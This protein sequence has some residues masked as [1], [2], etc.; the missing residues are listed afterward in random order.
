M[1]KQRHLEHD[2]RAVAGEIV[3]VRHGEKTVRIGFV[4]AVTPDGGILWIEGHGAEP[5][6]MFERTEGFHVWIEYK[7]EAGVCR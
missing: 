1:T 3:E 7:W 5:R 4:D 6:T 2:W